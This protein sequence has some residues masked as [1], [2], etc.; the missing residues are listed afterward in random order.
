MHRFTEYLLYAMLG[1]HLAAIAF[2]SVRGQALV[3]PMVT[4]DIPKH[5]LPPG[6]QS[7][8]DDWRVRLGALVLAIAFGT[9]AWWLWDLAFNA[10]MSFS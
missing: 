8:R 10:P 2:Y 9:L 1:L 5:T 7:A 6:T 3:K 4:G